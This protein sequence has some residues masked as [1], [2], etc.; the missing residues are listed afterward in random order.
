[1]TFLSPIFL[2]SPPQYVKTQ[3]QSLFSSLPSPDAKA[4]YH[5]GHIL[6]SAP[7]RTTF[8]EATTDPA[9][10]LPRRNLNPAPRTHIDFTAREVRLVLEQAFGG[11][12]A[13]RITA[14]ADPDTGE[15]KR[16]LALSVWRPLKTVR[17]DPLG[18]ADGRSVDPSAD[19]VPLRRTYPDGR[20]GENVVVK[21]RARGR[22]HDWYW[23][24][25]QAPDEVV[26]LKLCDSLQTALDKGWVGQVPHASFQLEG[27]EERP[28][29]ESVEVRVVLEW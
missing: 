12:A 27:Q 24:S 7:I 10:N 14:P 19:L 18:Y 17:R 15:P 3:A 6:R 23:L 21:S 22:T 2:I 16:F 13:E 4:V 25:E 8:T 11:E 20:E 9:W 1:M 26:V 28:V 29:R 5:L